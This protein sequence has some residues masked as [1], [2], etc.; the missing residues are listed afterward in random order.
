[1]NPTQHKGYCFYEIGLGYPCCDAER[2]NRLQ[3]SQVIEEVWN[4]L[5]I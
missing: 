5:G 3:I 4:V 2:F 1:M